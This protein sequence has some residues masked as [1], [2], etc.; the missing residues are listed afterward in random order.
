MTYKTTYWDAE[1][2]TQLVRNCTPEEIAEIEARKAS[3]QSGNAPI[4][5]QIAKLEG[6]VTPRRVREAITS[7]AG[8]L[9]LA[10]VDTQIAALRAQLK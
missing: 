10:G 2:K 1:T 8:A 5:A 7:E 3:P 6:T 9:W 4:L